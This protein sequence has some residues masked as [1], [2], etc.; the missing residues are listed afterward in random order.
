[1]T[2]RHITAEEIREPLDF[3][4]VLETTDRHQ[5]AVMELAEGQASGEFG[6]DHPQ[7]DQVVYVLSGGGWAR[8][9]EETIHLG[10]GDLLVVPAGVDHQILGPNRTLSF[11][12]PVAYPD[13]A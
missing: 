12:A 13:E 10:A 6:N 9:G 8:I 5:I 1:M 4:R 3:F 11:Y 7:A 2:M